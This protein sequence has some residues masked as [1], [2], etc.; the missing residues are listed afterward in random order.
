MSMKPADRK[1]TAQL[2]ELLAGLKG[3]EREATKWWATCLHQAGLPIWARFGRFPGPHDMTDLRQRLAESDPELIEAF[4][5][6][7]AASC[8]EL[9]ARM[10]T[11]YTPNPLPKHWPHHQV[12]SKP[13]RSA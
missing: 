6:S 2:R 3:K 12:V 13:S 10:G 4:E 1:F 11:P 9:Q 8:A 5:A 7:Y